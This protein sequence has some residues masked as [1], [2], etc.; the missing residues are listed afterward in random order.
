MDDNLKLSVVAEIASKCIGFDIPPVK[1]EDMGNEI[2]KTFNKWWKKWC[3]L[4][5]KKYKEVKI[6]MKDNM[7]ISTTLKVDW[8]KE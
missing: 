4:H 8:W 5:K 1:K 3:E 2:E 7:G 6:D